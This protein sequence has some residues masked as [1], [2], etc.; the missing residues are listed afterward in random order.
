MRA[1]LLLPLTLLAACNS[2]DDSTGVSGDEAAQ[3]NAAAD[4]LD[5]NATDPDMSANAPQAKE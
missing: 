1:I 4:M 5:I 3:L 2:T